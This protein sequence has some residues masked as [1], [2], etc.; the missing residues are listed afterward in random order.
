MTIRVGE[1][2]GRLT[3][4]ATGLHGRDPCGQTARLAVV[5]CACGTEHVVRVGNLLAGTT[6]SCGCLARAVASTR[7]AARRRA[8]RAA[9][10]P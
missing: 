8:E 9:S 4:I 7:M 1:V 3:V 6:T 5:R 2:F 10:T